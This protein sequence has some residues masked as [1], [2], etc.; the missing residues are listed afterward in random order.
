MFRPVAVL[1]LLSCGA[2]CQTTDKLA[3]D[4]VSIKRSP[5]PGAGPFSVGCR[6]GPG[7]DDPGLLVCQ[8]WDLAS[9]VGIAYRSEFFHVSA[10]DWMHDARFDI[11]AKVPE[12]ATR[13][14]FAAMWQNMLAERFKLAVH[15]ETRVSQTYDQV[16]A[17]DGPKFKE[18]AADAAAGAPVR[19]PLS[20]DQNG[21]PSFG[22]GHPGMA[23]SRGRARMYYPQMT[24]QMLALQLSGQVAAPVHDET[25]LKGKYEI[26]LY[27]ASEGLLEKEPDAGPELMQALRDQLGL[28]LESTKAP[29]E[30]LVVDHAERVPTDN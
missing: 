27:W 18:A 29:A 15:R 16:V 9:L 11:R 20:F 12:G 26:S 6:G 14:Q 23:F 19:G 3:F 25:G 24:M 28:R 22:P 4:V 1:V 17:K 13:D 5:P 30:F 21:Y 7:T 10:P 8:N 2:F